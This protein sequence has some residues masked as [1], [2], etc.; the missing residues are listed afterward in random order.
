MTLQEA[1]EAPRIWTQGQDLEVE[2]SVP[3]TVRAAR[4]A[5]GHQVV[6]VATAAV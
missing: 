3:D 2:A 4:A 6:S 1:L 5:R